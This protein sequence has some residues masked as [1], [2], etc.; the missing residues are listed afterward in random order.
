MCL[1]PKICVATLGTQRDEFIQPMNETRARLRME[2]ASSARRSP[3]AEEVIIAIIITPR[4]KAT[5][6]STD[7]ALATHSRKLRLRMSSP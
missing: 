1:N 3:T 5:N 4:A 6:V 7:I 2:L